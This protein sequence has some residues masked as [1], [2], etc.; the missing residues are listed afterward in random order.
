VSTYYEDLVLVGPRSSAPGA[1]V[2]SEGRFS[3][4]G[5]RA[6]AESVGRRV[7]LGGLVVT[8]GFVDA[9]VHLTSTGLMLRGLDLAGTKNAASLARALTAHARDTSERFIWGQ[10]WDDTTWPKPPSSKII[11][12]AAPERV[13][14][15]SRVD[16]HSAVVSSSLFELAGCESLDGVERD[17]GGRPTG[18]LRRDAHHAARRAFLDRLPVRALAAAHR[19]AAEQAAAAGIT[20]VHEMGGPVQGAGERDLDLFASKKL[21]IRV[22]VYYA[23]DDVRI[24]KRR[25]L[26]RIGGDL[27]IDGSLGSRTAAL[28]EPYTDA[29]GVTG[30]LYRDASAAADVFE[31]A[32]RAGLQAGVHCIGDAACEAA[33]RG[34]EIAARRCGIAAVR[35]LRHRLEH[36]EMSSADLIRRAARL[37]A[38]LSVQ[39]AFDAAWGG[40][41]GMYERRLGRRARGMNDFKTMR[42]SGAVI[43]FGSDSPVTPLDPAGAIRAARRPSVRSHSL[44]APAAFEAATSGAAALAHEHDRGMIAAGAAADF[45]V[46]TANP[47]TE[48]EAR[49]VATFVDGSLAFGKLPG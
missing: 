13:V 24:P 35:T 45:V 38:G 21:P 44:N 40:R 43:G 9:H 26:G 41:G 49:V 6:A 36:F 22:L 34:L 7:R 32:T 10:G 30:F 12:K 17:A 33:V 19:A 8:P 37:G 39:P 11:D 29:A 18:V 42:S 23:T 48:A 28:R 31:A 20:T 3:S 27:N 14:Y 5:R 4:V 47:I 46:W 2:V 1:F 15:C 25:R 16:G